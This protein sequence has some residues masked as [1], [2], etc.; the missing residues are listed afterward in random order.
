MGE[1]IV[2]VVIIGGG[3]SA[4]ACAYFLR[5][6]NINFIILDENTSPGGAW[7]KTWDSLKLFSP[8]EYSSLPGWMMPPTQDTYPTRSEIIH[9][10]TEYEKRYAFE[11]K[12]PVQVKSVQFRDELFYLET[13]KGQIL[14]KALVSA[15]GN[16]SNPFIPNY[17]GM[18]EF[19]GSQIHSAQYQNPDV[20]SGKRVLIVGG[21]NS[22]AQ[23]LSEVSKVAQTFWVTKEAP[24][25]LPDDVDGRYLF[26]L[27]TRKYQAM[28]KG[29]VLADAHDL[30]KIVM[31]DAV[32]DAR[33]RGVLTAL[34]PFDHLNSDSVVWADGREEKIDAIIWC[35]GFRPSLSHLLPLSLMDSESGAIQTSGPHSLKYPGL[36]FMGYGDWAGFAAATLIG[37]QRWAKLTASEIKAFLSER[38][39]S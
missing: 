1:A 21:G 29:E 24:A 30:A 14:T 17:Q 5:R 27:A 28:L 37:V 4:L 26:N 33:Q 6:E 34:A 13:S 19:R 36:W 7:N 15:T 12:R 25:F 32:K 31:L 3:Q 18:S 9:Y 35:T 38:S 22:A 39:S 20:F 2:D 8:K 16:W 11:I 23:I 10:L